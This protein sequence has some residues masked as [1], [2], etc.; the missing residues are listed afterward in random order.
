MPRDTVTTASHVQL[1][2][3]YPSHLSP[4]PLPPP[5]P[6]LP[7]LLLSPPSLSSREVSIPL[8]HVWSLTAA[9]KKSYAS[10]SAVCICGGG[11]RKEEEGRKGRRGGKE[12]RKERGR[13]GRG[14][15]HGGERREGERKERRNVPLAQFHTELIPHS[16]NSH[17]H[18]QHRLTPP[19]CQHPLP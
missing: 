11:R 3:M 8:G 4:N 17:P 6:S 16:H 14:G 15:R 10:C 12:G 2:L 5:P 18:L 19:C 9:V 7:S 13:K 1:T